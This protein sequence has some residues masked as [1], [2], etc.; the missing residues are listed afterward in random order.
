[1]S[2]PKFTINHSRPNFEGIEI[3]KSNIPKTQN[4]TN[5]FELLE[6]TPIDIEHHEILPEQQDPIQMRINQQKKILDEKLHNFAI[7]N[8][9]NTSKKNESKLSGVFSNKYLL[10]GLIL[11]P[12]LF[13]GINSKPNF[14][15]IPEAKY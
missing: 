14:S 9:P 6:L 8:K 1:M 4:N 2:K 13:L 12:L 7:Q 5:E 11:V 15:Y 3:S 10:S